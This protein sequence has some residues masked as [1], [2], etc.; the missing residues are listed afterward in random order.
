MKLPFGYELSF[1]RKAAPPAAPPTDLSYPSG[2]WRTIWGDTYVG[3]WQQ[4]ASIRMDSVLTFSAVFACIRLIAHDIGKLRMRLV[5]SQETKAGLIWKEVYSPAFSPVLKKPNSHQTRIKFYEQW[6]QQKFTHGAAY[7]LKHRDA[8]G[9]VI[10]MNVLDST[11]CEPLV[12]E[13]TGEVYYKLCPEPIANLPNEVIVPASE[14]IHDVYMTFDHP[15]LGVSPI[16]ACGLAATQGVKIQQNS[17][18]FF[19]NQSRAGVVLSAPGTIKNET[20]ARIKASWEANFG[21]E[22]YGRTAVLGDGLEPKTFTIT[23]EDAQLIQQLDWTAYDVCRAFGVPPYK[24]GV[25]PVPS[26]NNIEAL[27]RGYYSQTLQEPIECIE[28]LLDEGLA[29]PEKYGTEFDVEEGLL[30]MD[31]MSQAQVHATEI[32]AGYLAPNEA[33]AKRGYE[34]VEGGDSPMSQQQNFSLAALAKRDA[35]ADPFAK[36][37]GA[38]PPAEQPKPAP[39]PNDPVERFFQD[40]ADR[41]GEAA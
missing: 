2:S 18:K 35:Q 7:V 26:Y 12:S 19:R 14:I 11:R 20:A 10:G 40:L 8:R 21:G 6:V 37:A 31:T 17:E 30:R 15:L 39:D 3:G 41:L 1:K 28:L 25:G 38:A 32:R 16:G 5:E 4:D 36:D 22:N 34:P 29:L 33:R 27:A 24:I 9:I 13:D 23:A